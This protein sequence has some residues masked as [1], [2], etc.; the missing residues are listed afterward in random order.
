VYTKGD[1]TT[2]RGATKTQI[3]EQN[4]LIEQLRQQPPTRE[5]TETAISN[6]V[7]TTPQPTK[8]SVGRPKGSGAPK[9]M[10]IEYDRPGRPKSMRDPEECLNS[11][12]LASEPVSE[13]KTPKLR[14]PKKNMN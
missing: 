13:P 7:T 11:Q 12:A 5:S 1:E 6:A 4:Q 10:R 3:H 8:K 14:L 9:P 2:R